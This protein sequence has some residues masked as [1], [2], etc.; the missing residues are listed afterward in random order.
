MLNNKYE[1]KKIDGSDE[2]LEQYALCFQNNGTERDL[3]NLKWL[4]QQNVARTNLIYNAL[5]EIKTTASIYTALPA[6]A[7]I[8]S[9]KIRALQSIDTLTDKAHRGKGL[10]ILLAKKLYED[11]AEQG[12]AFV[13]GFPN[14]NSAPG[15]F[16]K[17]D[18]LSFGEVPFLIK[19]MRISYFI[20]KF[21][22]IKYVTDNGTNKP[23]FTTIILK[24][25]LCIK[26]LSHFGDDY[27]G[28][29]NRVSGKITIAVNRNS[30][31]LNW[32]FVDK[33]GEVYY[34]Y[35]M[36]FQNRLEAIIVFTIKNKHE[37]RVAYI[38]EY[39]Y[40]PEKINSAKQLLKFASSFMRKQK[41]DVILAWC[42]PKSFNFVAYQKCGFH[43]FHKKLRP[44]KLFFGVKILDR[45]F[46]EIISEKDNW[47][48]SYADS[49]TV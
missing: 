7:L 27:D 46:S 21:L 2:E 28:L 40:D 35:G 49:D 14:E 13:Y 32:R 37:G 25:D 5:D 29:W 12:F 38:M 30:E 11:A 3:E 45:K 26:P 16:K 31:Y 9:K 42:L 8:E 24:N 17:L 36:Y 47:Y 43:N 33:P 10:F 34:K 4:H 22:K 23:K 19:P 15:F 44:Q 41:A 48:I 18:W 20:K 39:L 1:I 6:N